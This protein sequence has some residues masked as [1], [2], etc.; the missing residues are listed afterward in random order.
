MEDP[1][2]NIESLQEVVAHQGKSILRQAEELRRWKEEAEA[3]RNTAKY[4]YHVLQSI[5]ADDIDGQWHPVRSRIK[6]AKQYY[7]DIISKYPKIQDNGK[8]NTRSR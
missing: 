4:L 1:M 6:T 3:W 7:K 5:D 8:D 2:Q